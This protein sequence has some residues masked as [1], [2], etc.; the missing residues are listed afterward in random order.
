LIG[1]RNVGYGGLVD[2][3]DEHVAAALAGAVRVE[4]LPLFRRPVLRLERR[5]RRFADEPEVRPL[6]ARVRDS[7][8]KAVG[9]VGLNLDAERVDGPACRVKTPTASMRS[10]TWLVS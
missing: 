4:P 6:A 10:T 1:P 3:G 5:M 7:R 8:R 9:H 2:E